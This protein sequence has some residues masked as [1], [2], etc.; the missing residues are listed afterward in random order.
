MDWDDIYPVTMSEV[1]CHCSGKRPR[2]SLLDIYHPAPWHA[3]VA[4]TTVFSTPDDGRKY[5]KQTDDFRK[6]DHEENIWSCKIG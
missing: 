6:K 3:P 2:T 5:D 1:G 4:A